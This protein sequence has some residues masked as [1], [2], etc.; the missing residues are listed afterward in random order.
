MFLE[1]AIAQKY[2]TTLY[3]VTANPISICGHQAHWSNIRCKRLIF[4][5]FSSIFDFFSFFE[6]LLKCCYLSKIVG[7]HIFWD[8]GSVMYVFKTCKS[9]I[10]IWRSLYVTSFTRFNMQKIRFFGWNFEIFVR[11]KFLRSNIFSQR[12][13]P[14]FSF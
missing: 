7:G 1:C 2:Q 11:Q 5:L 3:K 10:V 9:R 14:N 6:C 13:A 12:R 4:A 8:T